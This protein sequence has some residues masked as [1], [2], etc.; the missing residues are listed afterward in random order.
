MTK[1]AYLVPP[2][3]NDII[4][5]LENPKVGENER[6]ALIQRLEAT[7]DHCDKALMK[8]KKPSPLIPR[9]AKH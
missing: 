3:V 1:N 8:A 7:R 2:A 4:S 9:R 5:Q 6:M